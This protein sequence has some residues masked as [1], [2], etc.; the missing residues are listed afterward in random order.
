MKM[1]ILQN[2]LTGALVAVITALVTYAASA[3]QTKGGQLLMKRASASNPTAATA[4]K[5]HDCA[6]CQDV[7]KEVKLASSKGSYHNTTRIVE[8]ACPT[9]DTKIKTEGQGKAARNFAVHTCAS[10][11]TPSCCQ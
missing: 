6:K 10:G 9:C 5:P 4:V 7:A 11:T 8:H 1:R 2:V 3:E